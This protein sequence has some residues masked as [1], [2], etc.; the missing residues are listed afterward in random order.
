MS[1]APSRLSAGVIV[2][3]R[4]PDGWR[5]LVLRA[6]NNWDCPKGMVE[7]GEDPLAAA[8][9]EVK[10]ET[11]IEDLSFDWGLA[12][13]ETE[14]YGKNK[15]ARLYLAATTAAEVT[16]PVSPELGHPEHHEF[17]WVDL[18][19]AVALCPPRLAPILRWAAQQLEGP[20]DNDKAGA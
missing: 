7:A 4:T 14:P 3:R 16:L 15:V 10:E 1:T 13:R 8:R 19:Q 17:R 5:F 18:E 12:Y 6:F 2:V 11:L 20:T 9:R